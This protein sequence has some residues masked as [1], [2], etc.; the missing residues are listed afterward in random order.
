MKFSIN[1]GWVTI[2]LLVLSFNI[3][4]QDYEKVVTEYGEKFLSYSQVFVKYASQRIYTETEYAA[5][6]VVSDVA[7]D[8]YQH[9]SYL[10]DYLL[11][12]K[13][14]KKQEK[15]R[16]LVERL[17]KLRLESAILECDSET[18]RIKKALQ[19]VKDESI[20]KTANSLIEDLT[21]LKVIFEK[22][23][24]MDQK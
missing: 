8:F 24:S 6:L 4:S 3:F 20:T 18:K 9:N 11:I 14:L 10:G 15:E 7:E 1:W 21:D 13:I 2:V 16:D 19:S 22:I 17:L 5:A 23:H 12:L